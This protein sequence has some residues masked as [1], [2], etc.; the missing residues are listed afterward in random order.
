MNEHEFAAAHFGRVKYKGNEIIPE[1]CPFCGGGRHH[2]KET[3]ALNFVNHTF[4]CKRGSCGRQGHFSELCKQFGEVMDNDGGAAAYN[5]MRTF[6]KQKKNYVKSEVKPQSPTDKILEYF[7]LRKISQSTMEAF[8]IGADKKGNIVFPFYRNLQD[9]QN[10]TPTF[11]KFRLPQKFVKG[12]GKMKMWRENDTEP[13]L[14][15]M[16]LCV[17]DKPL[18]LIEGEF[19]CMA[20][21]ESGIRNCVSLPSGVDDF[22]WIDTCYNFIESYEQII[23]FG[24]NDEAGEK[25]VATATKKLNHHDLLLC[26][27]EKYGGCKDCNEILFK[28]GAE[29]VKEVYSSAK[30]IPLYGVRDLSEVQTLDLS[31]VHKTTTGLK[32]FDKGYGGSLDGDM[33]IITGEPGSGKSTLISCIMNNNI[34]CGEKVCVYSGELTLEHYSLWAMLQAAGSEY[35]NYETDETTGKRVPTVVTAAAEAIRRWWKGKYFVFD[36][37]IQDAD[38]WDTILS[39][40]ESTYKRYDVKTFVIDNLMT[41]DKRGLDRDRYTAEEYFIQKF[42]SFCKR[43]GVHGYLVV[44]PVKNTGEKITSFGQI[45]GS[46]TVSRAANNVWALNQADKNS[47]HDTEL[48]SLKSRMFGEKG[49]AKLVF[50]KKTKQFAELGTDFPVY[51]WRQDPIFLEYLSQKSDSSGRTHPVRHIPS[52]IKDDF[53]SIVPDDDVEIPF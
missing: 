14:F 37:S 24:D 30:S 8:G 42:S 23:F 10:K 7:D 17:P 36:L 38:K 49:L 6:R 12:K 26:D 39:V 29:R 13:I 51:S 45:S 44:H 19:D 33:T 11:N 50:N 34:D 18:V 48:S 53:D 40:F 15:G 43:L 47:E 28:Y 46:A 52:D 1:L 22:E 27:Y 4:N 9:Y 41:V 3:F 16:H 32:S 5:V 2:D 21:Y 25:F 31:K 35:V 20:A